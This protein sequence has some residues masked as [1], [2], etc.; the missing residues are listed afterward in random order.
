MLLALSAFPVH[1]ESM[2]EA[3][4]SA[5]S[6]DPSFLGAVETRTSQREASAQARALYLPKLQ[7]QAGRDETRSKADIEVPA[8]YKNLV[9]GTVEGGKSSVD[10]VLNQPLYDQSAWAAA[11][12]LQQKAKAAETNFTAQEQQLMLRV[13]EAWL[14]LLAVEDDIRT[15]KAQ[16]ATLATEV[17]GAEARF[18][19]G[20]ARITDV[21]ESQAQ[22]D[23]L[24]AQEFRV[25]S[26]RELARSQYLELIGS[27][28]SGPYGLRADFSPRPPSATL[29]QWQDQADKQSPL[30]RNS[31]YQQAAIRASVDQ[32]RLY[33]RPQVSAVATYS[34]IW[35]D[36]R[37]GGIVSP[38]GIESYGVGLRLTVPLGTGGYYPSKLREASA[39]SRRADHD[40]DAARRDV[41]L[42]IQKS[43]LGVSYGVE[44]IKALKAALLSSELQLRAATIG[45]EVG[46]RTQ[47]DVLSAQSQV[48]SNRQKLIAAS[49]DYEKERL[50]LA[51]TAGA[52]D[53]ALLTEVEQDFGT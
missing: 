48:L 40:V 28:F 23:Q 20:S 30:I 21:R 33:G 17:K 53:E 34:G 10:L 42:Q 35:Q 29:E 41:R 5:R 49:Y 16:K 50:R 52:L 47:S 27:D 32:Y 22:Y 44:E 7:L 25:L 6:H 45:R 9:G 14:N 38:H 3:W 18:A 11:R 39:D 24:T 36:D 4:R 19:L 31:E 37:G 8:A 2:V 26:Q 13:A 46:N 51:A 12:A 15:L 1:A 43:W